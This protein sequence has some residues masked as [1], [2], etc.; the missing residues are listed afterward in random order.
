MTTNNIERMLTTLTLTKQANVLDGIQCY[1]PVDMETLN[2]LLS[3]DLLIDWV[4][5]DEILGKNE[6]IDV[7]V[8]YEEKQLKRYK[9]L[10]NTDVKLATIEYVRPKGMSFG[11]SNPKRGIGMFSMRRL[12]RHT[13]GKRVKLTDWD[14]VNCHPV[15]LLQIAKKFGL[16][17]DKLAIYVLDRKTILQRLMNIT[18]CDRDRAKGLFI[19]LLY[20]GSFEKW[21]KEK[22]NKKTGEIINPEIKIETFENEPDLLTFINAF[23]EE[24]KTIGGHIEKANPVISKEVAKNKFLKNKKYYNKIGS[25]VSYFLQEIEIRVLECIY[26]YCCEQGYIQDN[27][28]VL[29]ADGIM[30]VEDLIV[31]RDIAT[32]F[33]QVV[34][35]STGFDLTF[36]KKELDE[37]CIDVLDQHIITELSLDRSK[38]GRF[39]TTYFNSLAGYLRK[40]IYF[41]IFV[42]KVLRPD[43]VFVYVEKERGLDNMCFYSYGK[44]IE[45][46]SHLKSGEILDNGEEMKFV[47]KWLNDENIRCFNSMG[48]FPYTSGEETPEHVFNLFRG[49][50]DLVDTPYDKTKKEKLLKPFHDLGVQLCGGNEKHYR[51][52]FK[53]LADIIQNPLKKNPL[54][55]IIKGKQGTGKNVWLNAIGHILSAVHFITSSNPKDLFGDHAEGFYHKLLVNMNECEGKDTFE[56]E[57]RIKSFI[58]EDTITLNRKFV[59]PVSVLNLARLIIFSN[60]PNPIPIDVRSK[61]RRYVVYETTDHY[62]HSKFGTEFWMK[63]IAHFKR[64]DFIACLYD[65]LNDV[66]LSETD[67]KSERPITEAY[68]QMCKLYVP[69]EALFLENRIQKALEEDENM[70]AKDKAVRELN[71]AQKTDGFANSYELQSNEIHWAKDGISGTT[72]Y[73]DYMEFCKKF[74][75]YKD[76][77]AYQKDNRKFYSR[78]AELDLPII[79]KKPNG[80]VC[81]KFAIREVLKVMKDKKWIDRSDEDIEE[82]CDTD[83]KGDDF[84][85]YFDV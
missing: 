52:L 19:R 17:C 18:G 85:D 11:R 34:K 3:S 23:A 44:I 8:G 50:S 54:A 72:L 35:I 39:D 25:V 33:H 40:K 20:F 56:Y 81:F 80:S 43:P 53:Y 83:V 68:L 16:A 15:L 7:G 4:F 51:F 55:F 66:D 49:F 14:I 57:G 78:L 69:L 5:E 82:I 59:Q 2:K 37:D 71:E 75:F 62:L 60:K 64:P 38:Y 84:T 61:D 13:L 22:K 67:W 1:E 74:G 36:E 73:E 12:I 26:K 42:C 21:L 65:D 27:I 32:E 58:T 29:C 79:Q 45:A 30:L 6:S 77:S 10:T 63:I 47:T 70:K 9:S 28:C 31:D 24:I 48:F 41:E 46:F 76:N